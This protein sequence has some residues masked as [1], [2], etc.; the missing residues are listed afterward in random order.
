MKRAYA[1][2]HDSR[3]PA[4]TQPAVPI[5]A[6][7]CEIQL[8]LDRDELLGLMQDSLESLALKLGM[9]VA[10]SL[11]E[12]EVTR[13]CGPRHERQPHRTH[14]RYGHQRGTATL[15]GQKIPI[16]HPRVRRTDGG[17]VPLET[18][19]HLQSPDAMPEAVLRR[20]VRG[21]ST[22]DYENVIDL[23]QDGFGVR[24]SSVSRDFVRASTAQVKA[25]AERRF[26]GTHFPVILIDG[27]EYAGETM[28]VAAGIT[29]DGTKCLLGLRQDAT[30]NAA[31]CV[32]LLED[33]QARGLD[34]SRPMLLV[35]DGAKA[36][37]AAAR[38]VWGQNGVIQR[39]QLHKKRNVKAHVPEKHTTPSWSG[40][41][42]RRT[43]RRATRPPGRR[44]RRRH[45]GWSGWLRACGKGWRRR[46]RWSGWAWRGRCVGRWPRPIPSSRPS[47]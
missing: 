12:D 45:V 3:K 32:A 11:L 36:L 41:S 19:A 2:R 30:E 18:Y 47:R 22:R 9:L 25:L 7:D 27:V 33:L 29:A 20:M 5:G 43:T 44:W 40:A 8:S 15:A 13:L 21:V 10:S 35:L 38:R 1:K 28:I 17:E 24:K 14:T 26:D 31:V 16:A 6:T 37:H 34:A 39:C 23:T 46:W 4:P 42:R